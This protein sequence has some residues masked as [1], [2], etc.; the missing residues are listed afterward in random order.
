MAT[1]DDITAVGQNVSNQIE[2]LKKLF[3]DEKG[4][5]KFATKQDVAPVLSLYNN[6]VLSAK[7][8]STGGKWFYRIVLTLAALFIAWGVLLGGFKGF[9]A[10]LFVW[11]TPK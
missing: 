2:E 6:I 7:I 3:L 11:A 1:K 10:S 8:T 5:P 4:D 9:L